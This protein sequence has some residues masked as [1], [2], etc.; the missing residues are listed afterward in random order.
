MYATLLNVIRTP[1][2]TKDQLYNTSTWELTPLGEKYI[3]KLRKRHPD[4]SKRLARLVRS[5]F[6]GQQ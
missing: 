5:A 2:V 4:L 6:A 1:K 3:E